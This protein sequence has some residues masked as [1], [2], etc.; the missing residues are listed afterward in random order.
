MTFFAN[1]LPTATKVKVKKKLALTSYH[2]TYHT[3]SLCLCLLPSKLKVC[4]HATTS[5]EK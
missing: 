1:V 5:N 4:L 3:A 2:T